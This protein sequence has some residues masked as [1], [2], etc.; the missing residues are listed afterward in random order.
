LNNILGNFFQNTIA[1][2]GVM[3][4]GDCDVEA[5]RA[6]SALHKY[7]FKFLGPRITSGRNFQLQASVSWGIFHGWLAFK[8]FFADKRVPASLNVVDENW[9]VFLFFFLPHFSF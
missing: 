4:V 2:P 7:A 3:A 6:P 9:A 8:L 1:S 5:R